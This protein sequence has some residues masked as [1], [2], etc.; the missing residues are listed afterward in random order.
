MT[1]AAAAEFA[2]ETCY[3]NT[4]SMGLPPAA[5]VRAMTDDIVAWSSGRREPGDY[6]SVVD[7]ARRQFA[8]LVHVDPT[9]VALGHQASPLV[10]LAAASVPDGGEVVVAAEEFTSV[11]FPFAAHADR[12]VQV[13]EVPLGAVADAIGPSTAWVAVSAVQSASGALADLDA[14]TAAARRHGTRVLLDLTQSAGW[15]DLDASR[16]D[17]TVTSGY[18]WLLNP[19]G[20]AFLTVAP[21]LIDLLRPLAAGWFAGDDVWSSI[22]GLP[23]RL[24]KDARRFDVSPG[25]LAW[26]GAEQSLDLLCRI[27]PAALQDHALEVSRAFADA[28]GLPA[29]S[30]AI[31]SLET[32]SG[33]GGEVD[34]V[35][36]RFRVVA[37][38]RAGRL[39]LSFH[40]HNTVE[41]VSPLGAALAGLLTAV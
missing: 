17:M 16:F 24:A 34:A 35:L 15:L 23:L 38:H 8:D 29:P 2:P 40:V 12:G 32:A 22:Y 36:E 3:L 39:R 25:W 19:R 37:A 41:E 7:H 10:G 26:V 27:G 6:D 18:K 21:D 14:I 5:T 30:S 1:W 20:T 33:A 4:A 31:L 9:L 28:A 11:T 13:R